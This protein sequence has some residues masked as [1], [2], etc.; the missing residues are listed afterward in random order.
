MTDRSKLGQ[1]FTV[2]KILQQKVCD[3]IKNNPTIILEP[4][5]GCGHLLTKVIEKYK[6]AKF[7]CYEIDKSL[8]LVLAK[9][10]CSIKVI[11]G[12]FLLMPIADKF[13]TIIGNPPYVKTKTGNLYLE[14]IEKCYNLLLNDGEM[15]MIVPS[16]F[17]KSTSGTALR[18]KLLSTG[19]ITDIYHIDDEHLFTDATID[20]IVFR[21]QKG[22]TGSVVNYNDESNILY[23]NG[24]ITIGRS[25][26]KSNIML[27]DIFNIY[28]GMVTGAEEVFK[29]PF[30]N[31][32]VRN[33]ESIDNYILINKFPSA[34]DKINNHLLAHKEQLINRRIR[35]F[36]NTN[37]FQWGALRNIKQMKLHKNKPCIYIKTLTRQQIIATKATVDYFGGGLIIL[38]PLNLE[39]EVDL[40]DFVNYFN[41]DAFKKEYTQ[42]GRFKIGHRQL[43]LVA[44]ELD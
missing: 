42:S 11:Y 13:E 44:V 4:S 12:D 7:I 23:N 39:Y 2:N 9:Q 18:N 17:L 14:F 43:S 27:K 1:Y 6:T 37:W 16:D 30:G 29:V 26:K 35:K 34:S 28:V 5:V 41:S 21:Y 3:L 31:I 22:T 19:S 33:Q 10:Q 25:D 32:K 20:V 8:K 38:I 40:D 24:V 15:I 36:N